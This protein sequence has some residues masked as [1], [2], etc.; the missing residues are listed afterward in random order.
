M[1]E[2]LHQ[3]VLAMVEAMKHREELLQLRKRHR[4]LVDRWKGDI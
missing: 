4:G 3:Y 2:D 1:V